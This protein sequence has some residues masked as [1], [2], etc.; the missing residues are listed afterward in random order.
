MIDDTSGTEMKS[1]Q[2]IESRNDLIV[3]E[4]RNGDRDGNCQTQQKE[5]LVPVYLFKRKKRNKGRRN[6]KRWIR[7]NKSKKLDRLRKSS[8]IV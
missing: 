4:G 1:N 5:K 3:T 8:T 7:K 6:K 2:V